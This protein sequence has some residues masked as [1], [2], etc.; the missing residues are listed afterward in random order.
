[1][2]RLAGSGMVCGVSPAA[3][4]AF[5]L[6]VAPVPAGLPKV[7]SITVVI[8]YSAGAPR[9]LSKLAVPV[10]LKSVDDSSVSSAKP[11]LMLLT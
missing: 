3:R 6:T 1:M 2:A 10:P 8:E 7:M 11:K 4:V 5:A 9:N